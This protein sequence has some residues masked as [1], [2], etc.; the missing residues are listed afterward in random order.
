MH[1]RP[2]KDAHGAPKIRAIRLQVEE[3]CSAVSEKTPYCRDDSVGK[4][5][6]RYIRRHSA[7]HDEICTG[8][9]RIGQRR[10]HI[11]DFVRYAELL[12][13]ICEQFFR[14]NVAV[15]VTRNDFL[16]DTEYV[17]SIIVLSFRP[18]SHVPVEKPSFFQFSSKNGLPAS[19]D[20]K[21]VDEI[22][23]A[24]NDAEITND[25]NRNIVL[26]YSK[27]IYCSV[28]THVRASL[29]GAKIHFLL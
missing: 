11:A 9:A 14:S 22:I 20:S 12:E 19:A 3:E 21:R 18:L 23:S 27:E 17:V 15:L 28:D 29:R 4:Y 10:C 25:M 6:H 8:A 16:P 26:I 24:D 1:F 7:E 5:L 13:R 2:I